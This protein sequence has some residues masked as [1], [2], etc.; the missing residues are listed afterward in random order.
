MSLDK[1]VLFAYA[2]VFMERH[3]MVMY[4]TPAG[5]QGPVLSEETMLMVYVC[6]EVLPSKPHSSI[7]KMVHAV[8]VGRRGR[9]TS[10]TF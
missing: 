4:S 5:E 10:P 3:K 1:L 9:L 7:Y 2:T 8:S 6:S